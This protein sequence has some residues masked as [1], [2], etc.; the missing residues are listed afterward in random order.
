MKEKFDLDDALP[1]FAQAAALVARAVR[2]YNELCL[3]GSCDFLTSSQAHA[4]VG[5]LM[6]RWK[7]Y[8][9]PAAIPAP[10]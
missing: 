1:G 6:R 10:S 9:Q 5:P 7:N 3:H 8:Y 2:A 4:Q